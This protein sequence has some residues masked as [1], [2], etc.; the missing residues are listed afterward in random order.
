MQRSRCPLRTTDTC[1]RV[2]AR[3]A[4]IRADWPCRAL[5]SIRRLILEGEGGVWGLRAWGGGGRGA[6][7]AR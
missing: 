4:E 2:R 1:E 5:S 6:M 3:S 7:E